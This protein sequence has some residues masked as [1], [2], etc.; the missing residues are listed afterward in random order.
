MRKEGRLPTRL[1]H[2]RLSARPSSFWIPE[3]IYHTAFLVCCGCRVAAP[4]AGHSHIFEHFGRTCRHTMVSSG[5]NVSWGTPTNNPN[6]ICV[7]CVIQIGNCGLAPHFPRM[8]EGEVPL[9][10]G[11]RCCVGELG[12]GLQGCGCAPPTQNKP[13]PLERGRPRSIRPP[14]RSELCPVLFYLRV[15]RHTLS[16]TRGWG[17]IANPTACAHARHHHGGLRVRVRG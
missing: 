9:V 12:G 1:A 3:F 2:T 10:W 8:C 13:F 16:A 15:A 5:R 11:G 4:G 6:Q 17:S 7:G 14:E